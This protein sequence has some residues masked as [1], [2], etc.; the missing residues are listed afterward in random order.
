MIFDRHQFLEDLIKICSVSDVE[1][2]AEVILDVDAKFGV[3]DSIDVQQACELYR[4]RGE[5]LSRIGVRNY[6]FFDLVRSL[7]AICQQAGVVKRVRVET[8][9]YICYAFFSGIDNSTVGGV[10]FENIRKSRKTVSPDWNS[11]E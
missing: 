1:V 7:Q 2:F 5:H 6:G 8:K 9:K 11:V 3:S 10:V 4:Q